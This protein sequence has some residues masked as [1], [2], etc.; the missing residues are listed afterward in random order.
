MD[1]D[2]LIDQIVEEM[3]RVWGEKGLQGEAEEYDWLLLHYNISEYDDVKWQ[4]VINYQVDGYVEE[5][6]EDEEIR[7]FIEDDEAVCN[8][9]TE[10]LRKYRSN[11][12]TYSHP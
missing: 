9:L 8:F 3:D 1:R 12:T 11:A 10:L 6:D 4:D 7:K 5:A 2:E